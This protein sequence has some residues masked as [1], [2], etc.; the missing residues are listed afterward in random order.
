MPSSKNNFR[1]SWCHNFSNVPCAKKCT[2]EKKMVG[3]GFSL[4]LNR[5]ESGLPTHVYAV[6]KH[7]TLILKAQERWVSLVPKEKGNGCREQLPVPEYSLLH[8]FRFCS[9]PF[10]GWWRWTITKIWRKVFLA[11]SPSMQTPKREKEKK[12]FNLFSRFKY[13]TCHRLK[14]LPTWAP[15]YCC[16][17]RLTSS[18]SLFC[19][20]PPPSTQPSR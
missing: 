13:F 10:D 2:Q 15:F 20:F 1:K 3:E 17:Q 5:Y 19:P 6:L 9:L 14:R 12:S 8:F 4:R 18:I 11:I 7:E 16:F